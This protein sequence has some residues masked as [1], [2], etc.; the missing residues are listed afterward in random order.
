MVGLLAAAA[1]FGGCSFVLVEGA[2][3]RDRWPEDNRWGLALNRCS[4]SPIL[5]LADS[6][7]VLSDA[8]LAVYAGRGGGD[9]APA[10]TSLVLLPSIVFIASAIYGF[11]ATNTCRTYLAGP[12]YESGGR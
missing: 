5:P 7:L 1:A 10:I 4:S 6:A 12:P 9:A 11:G 8:A 2:P 3:P